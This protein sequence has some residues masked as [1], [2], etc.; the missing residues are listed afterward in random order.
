MRWHQRRQ[1][2]NGTQKHVVCLTLRVIEGS[3]LFQSRR[4]ARWRWTNRN[5]HTRL[6][7]TQIA[8]C[9]ERFVSSRIMR[10]PPRQKMVTLLLLLHFSMTSIASF[11]VPKLVSRMLHSNIEP[12]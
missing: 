4:G 12:N 6:R 10:L 8:S 9:S 2:C 3:V 11:V 7:A 1:L 5:M